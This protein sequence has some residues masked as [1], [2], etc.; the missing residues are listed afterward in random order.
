MELQLNIDER[1][2]LEAQKRC[3]MMNCTVNELAVEYLNHIAKGA[4][5]KTSPFQIYRALQLKRA[6]AQL[7]PA[8]AEMRP[9]REDGE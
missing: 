3:E 7:Q 5:I 8:V 4:D 6:A 2:L 9:N 1:V